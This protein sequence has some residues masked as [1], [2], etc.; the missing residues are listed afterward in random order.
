VASFVPEARITNCASLYYHSSYFG[1]KKKLNFINNK[2]HNV[3]VLKC[4]WGSRYI[5]MYFSVP[6][7]FVHPRPVTHS[8]HACYGS[9][10]VKDSF[11]FSLRA[12]FYI[13]THFRL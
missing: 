9:G 6:F 8:S 10:Y 1:K 3:L 11:T 12:N 7:S 2:K 5:I 4:F 13:F